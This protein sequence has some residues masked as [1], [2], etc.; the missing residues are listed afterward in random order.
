MECKEG[1]LVIADDGTIGQVYVLSASERCKGDEFPFGVYWFCLGRHAP[2]YGHILLDRFKL[3]VEWA[4]DV[5]YI[6]KTIGT[7]RLR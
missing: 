3:N 2:H 5:G 1:D 6:S 7:D 4:L